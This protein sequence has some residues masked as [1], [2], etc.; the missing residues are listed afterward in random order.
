MLTPFDCSV[1]LCKHPWTS[2]ICL[3]AMTNF[4]QMLF[5]YQS[6]FLEPNSKS[7]LC[8]TRMTVAAS[9]RALSRTIS[10]EF[11][12]SLVMTQFFA[13]AG[14][15]RTAER[16]EHS[17]QQ[18]VGGLVRITAGDLPSP[19]RLAVTCPVL[20]LGS[21]HQLGWWRPARPTLP[22]PCLR[23]GAGC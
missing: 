9:P 15:T 18:P 12:R 8:S 13:D 17:I 22:D 7:A 10:H 23:D 5:I 19:N 2:K 16:V 4:S 11:P 3:C 21:C 6:A 14:T 20:Q 1:D